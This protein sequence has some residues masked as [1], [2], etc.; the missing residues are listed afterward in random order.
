MGISFRLSMADI[1]R[2]FIR[3]LAERTGVDRGIVESELRAEE[4]RSRA[5]SDGLDL[6][7]VVR[8]VKLLSGGD[9]LS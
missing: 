6:R 7:A 1:R 2:M 8:K 5:Q 3:R 4:A 9:I